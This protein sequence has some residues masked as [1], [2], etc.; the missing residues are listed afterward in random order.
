MTITIRHTNGLTT[1]YRD[2]EEV[3]AAVVDGYFCL[4]GSNK[5]YIFK[6]RDDDVMEV[7][8]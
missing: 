8:H 2:I 3:G 4:K 5:N 6:L 7:E 1:T